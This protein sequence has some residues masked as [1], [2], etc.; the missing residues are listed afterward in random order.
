M[1]LI[2]KIYCKFG[3]IGIMVTSVTSP[4]S[5]QYNCFLLGS[6]LWKVSQSK[7]TRVFAVNYSCYSCCMTFHSSPPVMPAFVPHTTLKKYHLKSL[8]RNVLAL[9]GHNNKDMRIFVDILYLI[10]FILFNYF[11]YY[12][13]HISSLLFFINTFEGSDEQCFLWGVGW[14]EL[15]GRDRSGESISSRTN[16]HRLLY[17]S[18]VSLTF[19]IALKQKTDN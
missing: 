11:Y 6:L 14:S 15:W 5:C 18:I 1:D 8:L 9:C 13:W 10:T 2:S 7:R 3:A 4:Y 16:I 19:R 12:Y 17:N